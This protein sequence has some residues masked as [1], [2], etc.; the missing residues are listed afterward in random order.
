MSV[1]LEHLPLVSVVMITYNHEAFIAEAI[2]GVLM[3]EVDF[4]VEL[5]IADDCS[6][7]RTSE[8]VQG[9]LDTHPKGHWIKYTRHDKNKGMMPNFVWALEQARGEFIAL[10]EG[11][12]YWTDPLKLQKQLDFLESNKLCSYVFT[13]RVS[14]LPNGNLFKPRFELPELFNLK[15][16]LERKIMPSTQTV[17]FTRNRLNKLNEWMDVMSQG[18]NGDWILLFMLTHDSKIG[19][20]PDNTAVYREGVGIISKS[21]I[22][23]ICHNGM[24]TNQRIN[25]LLQN[26]YKKYLL[27]FEWHYQRMSIEMF[28]QQKMLI[29]FI[30]LIKKEYYTLVYSRKKFL[31]KE[32]W[33]YFKHMVKLVFKPQ[34]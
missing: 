18:F 24:R 31:S 32:N 4:P 20:I 27:N 10:C 1:T 23:G 19:F 26:K 21:S 11:D 17:M 30:Y 25:E 28:V 22:I 7:D 5:I 9:Y 15:L 29:G 6:P 13:N 8:I 12:D 2:E 34:I 16:L 3:Q 14:L 33:N